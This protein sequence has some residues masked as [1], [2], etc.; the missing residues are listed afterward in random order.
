MT[1]VYTLHDTR[2]TDQ[3]NAIFWTLTDAQSFYP[4]IRWKKKHEDLW[5]GY[6]KKGRLRYMIICWIVLG[7]QPRI[8]EDT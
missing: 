8:P 6:S 7:E 5:E 2:E 1:V 4:K 3:L